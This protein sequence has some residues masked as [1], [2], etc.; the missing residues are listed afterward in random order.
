MIAVKTLPETTSISNHNGA[1]HIDERPAL[2]SPELANIFV[3]HLHRGGTYR[4]LWT[5]AGKLSEWF[6]IDQPVVIPTWMENK[7]VYFSVHPLSHIPQAADP[8]TGEVRSQEYARGTVDTVAAV[9]CFF[10]E[11]DGKDFVEESEYKP[12]L[13]TDFDLLPKIQQGARVK[14][15]KEEAFYA[16]PDKYLARTRAFT[17]KVI[18]QIGLEPSVIIFS[19]GGYHLYWLLKDTV[20][21]T[22]ENV[23]D[24]A[25]IQRDFVKMVGADNVC[26]LPR[27][28]RFP[29]TRNHKKGF[30][31]N[32][33]K[34]KFMRAN[35]ERLYTLDDIEGLVNDWRAL[36]VPDKKDVV[37][38]HEG[39]AKDYAHVRKLF[40]DK[41]SIADL[42]VAH[43]YRLCRDNDFR[44][45]TRMDRP[46][47]EYRSNG[48]ITVIPATDDRPELSQH[49]SSND[50]LFSDK[51]WDAYGINAMLNHDGDWKAA[52][53]A[54][55]KDVGLWED[56]PTENAT[57]PYIIENG[58][59]V[60]LKAVKDKKTDETIYT[61]IPL[62]NFYARIVSINRDEDGAESYVIAGKGVRGGDFKFEIP[63]LAY[64]D[65]GKLMSKLEAATPYDAVM[66]GQG[67]H[68][69]PAIKHLTEGVLE[70]AQ[71]FNRTGWDNGRFLIPGR[72]PAGVNIRL[73]RKLAYTVGDSTD[74]TNGL[75]GLDA[76]MSFLVPEIAPVVTA[77][78]FQAPLAKLAGW[79]DDRYALFIKGRTG[80]KKTTVS[81]L[82][83]S[84][85]GNGF[86]REDTL[87]KFGEGATRNA[88]MQIATGAADMPMLIDN[89]KPNTGGG[90]GDYIN[91]IHNLIEGGNKER[92]NRASQLREPKAIYTWPIFTGEDIPGNDPA[93]LA[94]T[95][96]VTFNP[97][98]QG[99]I[100]NLSKAQDMGKHLNA[101]GAAWLSW[102]ETESAQALIDQFAGSLNQK[103]KA[104]RDKIAALPFDAANPDRIATNLAINQITW[105]ILCQHPT[106]G[107]LAS[108]YRQFHESGLEQ[109]ANEMG[110]FTATASPAARFVS[111]LQELL[112]GGRVVLLASR[113]E[114]VSPDA[115]NADRVIGWRGDGG[116]AYLLPDAT[117]EIVKRFSGDNL[118]NATR[119]EL[120]ER[121]EDMGLIGSKDK[122]QRTK[123]VKIAGSPVKTLHLKAEAITLNCDEADTS[124]HN[125]VPE[126]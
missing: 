44:G 54:A 79:Q 86:I 17:I 123:T 2:D 82:L 78:F 28:L 46:G 92:L 5:L 41:H 55:K 56:N 113:S 15:A 35:L 30:A 126:F 60:Y 8:E 117:F 13:P 104:W 71:V 90:S 45:Y 94:R 1:V 112:A 9:N 100:D 43:D 63:T 39:A 59:M 98:Q 93:S 95:L 68:M 83:M 124:D 122:A 105:E 91:L 38:R 108:K 42:L 106:I 14:A 118:G 34:V 66:A 77:A 88:I 19:G 32:P 89:F 72:E 101:V 70:T 11:F 119:N 62:A 61:H 80:A 102:L 3:N 12:F 97:K 57:F 31:G 6:T 37:D 76:L 10:A 73:P 107:P 53:I 18:E 109:V 96:V 51:A 21:V 120:Y 125:A 48:S 103:R 75:A 47:A 111:H 50:A 24:I 67:S 33:P 74:L 23:K 65:T 114:K 26:D 58:R 29:G 110:R 84:M 27:V 115:K 4:Y 7:D 81:Q 25:D 20:L 116:S 99:N 16:D 64:G 121:L 49:W 87:I 85:Y 22:P 52:Y 69:A 36:Q 40:N